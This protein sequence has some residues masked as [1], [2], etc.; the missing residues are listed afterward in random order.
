ML[1][2]SYLC[3]V[4]VLSGL[5]IFIALYPSVPIYTGALGMSLYPSV[6]IFTGA[7]GMSLY[8]S[9]PIYTG[10]LGMSL[11]SCLCQTGVLDRLRICFIS[12]SLSNSGALRKT[13]SVE[14]VG[15]L[16]V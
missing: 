5:L 11:S 10:A 4:G 12:A 14:V 15:V 9:V 2:L 16:N 3:V 7:L 8:H 6:P 13:L 1:S